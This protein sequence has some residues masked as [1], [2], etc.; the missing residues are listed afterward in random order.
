MNKKLVISI[1]LIAILAVILYFI[2]TNISFVDEDMLNNSIDYPSHETEDINNVQP[3]ED[4][5]G[6][7]NV[8]LVHAKQ[9]QSVKDARSI[10]IKDLNENTYMSLLKNLAISSNNLLNPIPENC[11]ILSANL[12]GN[13]LKIDLSEEFIQQEVSNGLDKLILNS[14]VSTLTNLKEVNTIKINIE[15][16]TDAMLGQYSLTN[17]FSKNSFQ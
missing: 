14:I 4:I 8:Y 6:T 12:E 5:I 9:M 3:N 1:I 11:K 7:L 13:I 2:F 15:N 17:M 10:S 16:R